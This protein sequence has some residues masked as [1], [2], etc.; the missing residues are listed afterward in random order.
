VDAGLGRKYRVTKRNGEE[1]GWGH[2]KER[3]ERGRE[4]GEK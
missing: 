4:W 1:W 3:V 2:V